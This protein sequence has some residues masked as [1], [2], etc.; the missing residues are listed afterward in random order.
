MDQAMLNACSVSEGGHKTHAVLAYCHTT[1]NAQLRAQR[2]DVKV[3]RIMVQPI[4]DHAEWLDLAIE[5][6]IADETHTARFPFKKSVLVGTDWDDQF[7]DFFDTV[8]KAI[9]E[10]IIVF[11]PMMAYMRA[12]VPTHTFNLD[13]K[14]ES[15][16]AIHA[17]P[18]SKKRTKWASA[19]RPR[20][21]IKKAFVAKDTSFYDQLANDL[22]VTMK[23]AKMGMA[24]GRKAPVARPLRTIR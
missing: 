2:S 6:N 5:Y 12:S 19:E 11:L 24:L 21:A 22:T 9:N 7:Y 18:I 4:L 3:A 17:K 10:D 8:T 23:S 14:S 16:V 13:M 15:T 20:A 1:L